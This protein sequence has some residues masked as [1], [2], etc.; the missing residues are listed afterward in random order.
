MADASTVG[1]YVAAAVGMIGGLAS[2]VRLGADIARPS[3]APAPPAPAPAPRETQMPSAPVLPAH[4]DAEVESLRRELDRLRADVDREH[5][6]AD[7]ARVARAARDEKTAVLLARIA[8]RLKISTTGGEE[9]GS[10]G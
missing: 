10:N 9:R 2:L 3:P 4:R 8:E 1:A 5:A 6:T 7:A